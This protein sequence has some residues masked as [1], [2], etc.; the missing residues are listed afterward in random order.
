MLQTS[1]EFI[2]A[3]CG[4]LFAGAALYINAVEHP[5]RMSCGVQAAV[6]E[7]TPSYKRATWMQ[8]P[9][10]VVGCACVVIAWLAGSSVWWLIGGVSLGLVV[11]FT[12]LVIMPTN[13]QLLTV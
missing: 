13:R 9:L 10:A 12:H 8:A 4:A 7:W 2:A 3:L 11:P 5:A 6:T 1:M